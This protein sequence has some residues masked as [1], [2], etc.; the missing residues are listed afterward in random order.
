MDQLAIRTAGTIG[1]TPAHGLGRPRQDL[2]L[3]GGVLPVGLL[4]GNAIPEA[5]GVD[6]G[7]ET[8]AQLALHGLREFNGY[9]TRGKGFVEHGPQPLADTG[10]VDDDVLG[11][12]RFGKGLYFAEDGDVILTRPLLEMNCT[13][14]GSAQSLQGRQIYLNDAQSYGIARGIRL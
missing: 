11:Q 2:G 12:P 6:N 14:G 3:T 7:E 13:V 9:D 5:T 8:V 1:D 4:T 10:G